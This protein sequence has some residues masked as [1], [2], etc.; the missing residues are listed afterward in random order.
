MLGVTDLDVFYGD[1]QA[2]WDVSM[3]VDEGE[4]VAIVG[5]NGA[6]KSTF[7]NAVMGINRARRGSII[8]EGVEL[9]NLAGHRTCRQGIAI[10][11]EGRRLFPFLSVQENLDLGAFN[12]EA[13]RHHQESLAWVHEL[14][15]RLSERR[16]QLAG[17]L[18]GG[19]QQMVAIG[20]ALMARPRLLLMDEPS[21]GLAPVIVDEVFDRIERV[22]AEGVSVVLVEQNVKR[23][24]D[25]SARAYV[26]A[27]GRIVQQGSAAELAA[28]PEVVAALLGV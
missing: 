13:R 25:I 18:S 9:T 2:L 3:N 12:R 15:P 11:P 22:R 16:D 1:A 20:R 6:G 21:L 23:A 5:S 19:E 10:V 26:L 17:T 14:F 28:S 8:F 4:V 7:V 24:L 27:E